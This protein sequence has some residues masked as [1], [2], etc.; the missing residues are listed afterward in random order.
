MAAADN[1]S[2]PT[3]PAKLAERLRD[4]SRSKD[5]RSG[6]ATL[7]QLLVD[8]PQ[9]VREMGDGQART[10]AHIACCEDNPECLRVLLEVGCLNPNLKSMIGRT[11][12]MEAAVRDNHDC[13]AVLCQ[14]QE[15]EPVNWLEVQ[16][17][18]GFTVAH[19]AAGLNSLN[20][21]RV[22]AEQLPASVA[23]VLFREQ[24]LAGRSPAELEGYYEPKP[25]TRQLL[26]SLLEKIEQVPVKSAR[27]TG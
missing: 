25:E 18:S 15:A 6:A 27:K 17:R 9:N 4:T 20:S 19:F 11:P 2:R 26:Q 12:A 5:D 16:P 1:S 14:S 23:G 3:T 13:L 21:L 10:A 22:L 24:D 7:R 8:L